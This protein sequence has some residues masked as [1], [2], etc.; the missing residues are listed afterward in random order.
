MNAE[1]L[2]LRAEL[3]PDDETAHGLLAR[4]RDTATDEGAIATALR[5][6][7]AMVLRSSCDPSLRDAAQTALD[8]LDGRAPYPAEQGWMHAQ[9]ARLRIGR[10][11]QLPSTSA[12]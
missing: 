9:L 8:I 2:I 11:P 1:L 12:T 4:A 10:D 6:A 3:E 5:A 7:V